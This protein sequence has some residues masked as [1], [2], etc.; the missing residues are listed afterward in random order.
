LIDFHPELSGRFL[1]V[2]TTD[3]EQAFCLI[4]ET[5]HSGFSSKPDPDKLYQLICKT[6]KEISGFGNF[7]FLL[8]NGEYLFAHCSSDLHYLIRQHPFSSAQLEDLD[9]TIDFQQL[10]SPDDQVAVIATQPLTVNEDW[11]KMQQG[12]CLLFRDGDRLEV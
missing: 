1:P 4:L 6:T 3:S 2:G 8:S 10:T 5:M 11:I 7:N 12:E 9:M